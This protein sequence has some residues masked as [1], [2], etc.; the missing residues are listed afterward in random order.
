MSDCTICKYDYNNWCS[1]SVHIQG[2]PCKGCPLYDSHCQCVNYSYDDTC[3]YFVSKEEG[4]D[5]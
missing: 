5:D 2:T 3:P 1:K 4:K